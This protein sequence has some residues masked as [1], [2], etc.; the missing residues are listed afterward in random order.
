MEEMKCPSCGSPDIINIGGKKYQCRNC[1]TKS[2]L[3][4]DNTYLVIS[5]IPCPDCEF[6][7]QIDDKFCGNCGNKLIKYCEGCGAET[8]LDRNF[9][10]NC[11]NNKFTSET[12]KDVIIEP[13]LDSNMKRIPVINLLR[14]DFSLEAFKA[15]LLLSHGAVIAVGI[16]HD[17]ARELKEKYE[18][19]D[20]RIRITETGH[21]LDPLIKSEH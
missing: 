12:L 10:S 5:G 18:K 8:L 1:F 17:R 6:S 3:S 2:H 21:I 7:N 15:K 11:G 19:C 20:A 9:C 14:K 4:N 16:T 13:W